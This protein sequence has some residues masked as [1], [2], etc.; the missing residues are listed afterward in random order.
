MAARHQPITSGQAAER[1]PHATARGGGSAAGETHGLDIVDPA[2]PVPTDADADVGEL[3]EWVA[4]HL[5][6]QAAVEQYIAALLLS[7]NRPRQIARH[8]TALVERVRMG[9]AR[10]H[11]CW[12][13]RGSRKDA[14]EPFA[15]YLSV[16]EAADV[17]GMTERNLRKL[18]ARGKAQRRI[19]LVPRLL[20]S[21]DEVERLATARGARPADGQ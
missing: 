15:T 3:G 21:L 7:H 1:R 19:V 9:L 4:R 11:R 10:R 16:R 5:Q 8:L 17:L 12:C 6:R 13:R 14:A 20:L 2:S 18:I